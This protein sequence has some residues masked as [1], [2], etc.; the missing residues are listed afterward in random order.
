MVERRIVGESRAHRQ[1]LQHLQRVASSNVEVLISGPTGVGKELYAR[2]LHSQS[3]RTGRPFVPVNCGAVPDALFENEFFG[4]GAGAFTGAVGRTEGLVESAESGT[5]FLDE[6]DA[7]PAHLQVKLLRFLQEKEFRRLGETRVRRANV[8]IVAATNCD[9]VDKVRRGA[10]REDLFFR[11]RVAP[12]EVKA[13]AERRDDIDPLVDYFTTRYAQEYETEPV[14]YS[15][16]ARKAMRSY[17]WAGNVRE[18]QNCVRYLTAM[19][20]DHPAGPHDL[21]LLNLATV[22]TDEFHLTS[23]EF[24]TVDVP[25]QAAKSEVVGVFEQRYLRR[26]LNK[27]RGNITVAAEASGKNR[28]AFFELLRKH[29]IDAAAYRA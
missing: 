27:A 18:L 25:F 8:R 10:F 20:L 26:A 29:G 24:D 13:L 11:L 1:T 6:V 22:P 5:L 21:P 17:L 4:H 28:R 12:I 16:A 23:E 15:E 3:K 14:C 2:Y 19:Q 9:L 7:L